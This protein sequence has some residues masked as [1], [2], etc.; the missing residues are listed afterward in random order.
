MK[1]KVRLKSP[2][3]GNRVK[4]GAYGGRGGGINFLALDKST[5]QILASYFDYNW[6]KTFV[7]VGGWWVL[8][9]HFSVQPLGQDFDLRLEFRPKLNNFVKI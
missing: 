2:P 7:V 5:Y 4:F 6:F 1:S 3:L 8:E 9:T